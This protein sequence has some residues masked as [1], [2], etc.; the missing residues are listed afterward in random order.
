MVDRA[1]ME[2]IRH[3]GTKARRH[4]VRR[5]G[6]AAARIKATF[7]LPHPSCLSE[8]EASAR[9]FVPSCLIPVIRPTRFG[10]PGPSAF[11]LIEV[12]ISLFI[13]LLLLIG[14]NM[15]FKS[16]SQ[17]VQAGNTLNEATRNVRA[18]APVFF[19]DLKNCA[20]DS[21]AFIISSEFVPQFLNKA[22]A[23]NSNA[24][25]GAVP[26]VTVGGATGQIAG[27]ILNGHLFR[28]DTLAFFARGLYKRK[29]ANHITTGGV[30]YDFLNS[31][32]TSNEAY[33][34]YG[35]LRVAADGVTFVA[36]D[37]VGLPG[38]PYASSWVLGRNVTLLVDPRWVA[39]NAQDLEPTP[40]PEW[41][42]PHYTTGGV[43][44][45]VSAGGVAIAPNTYDFNQSAASNVTPLAV[46]T[47]T[48]S[49]PA[50]TNPPVMSQS[51]RYDL[52]AT[53]ID[54]YRQIIADAA[55]AQSTNLLASP[56]LTW[57]APLVYQTDFNKPDNSP[58]FMGYPQS[59]ADI[60]SRRGPFP[61]T[62]DFPPAQYRPLAPSPRF[63][64]QASNVLSPNPLTG[65]DQANLA[66]YML[67]HV[68]QFIVEYAGD[69]LTQDAA[70]NVIDTIPDG[71]VDWMYATKGLW[72]PTNSYAAGD[73]VI[74]SVA[75]GKYWKAATPI[76]G[77]APAT[78]NWNQS[79]MVGMPPRQIR[80]YG[81]PRDAVGSGSVP[82][83]TS[84]APF[85]AGVRG[86]LVK[87]P[88][89]TVNTTAAFDNVMCNVVPLADLWI[90]SLN[91]YKRPVPY[92]VELPGPTSNSA[93]TPVKTTA[94]AD[95]AT[96]SLNSSG[97]ANTNFL[98][99]QYT[100]YTAVWQN[101]VPAMV[102]ILIK[103]DD[104]N[105]VLQDGPWY[106][107]VVKLK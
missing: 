30:T 68:S 95:Y 12:M 62:P 25:A 43:A 46:N 28:A 37:D 13:G 82:A 63:R 52:A 80:W 64:Y 5:R 33:I 50:A 21:P 99:S 34:H 49:S 61:P 86:T 83:G 100:R 47:P 53:T 11:T 70:G 90:T 54:Q 76:V 96:G 14:M 24:I 101:D 27:C 105:N 102:R 56:Y 77:A 66:P 88:N 3:E 98:N 29:T 15:I 106:E 89:D 36:P 93:F 87:D 75:S 57:W 67:D 39:G 17:S 18:V 1:E 65:Q 16:A 41:V 45:V 85:A 19:E 2:T 31:N 107:Y 9:A 79:T 74:D 84:L 20:K 58:Q 91:N 26:T 55:Y 69:F 10:R 92:E 8:G 44:T 94:I 71:Q 6:S 38:Q 51:S 7:S 4:E 60:I 23:V 103:I 35:H 78:P 59:Y 72:K 40:K 42:Y 104:P 48:N 22:D 73:W 81:M 32:T 97:V